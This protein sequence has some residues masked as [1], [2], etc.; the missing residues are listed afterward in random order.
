MATDLPSVPE[1]SD[2]DTIS[3]LT[4][5]VGTSSFTLPAASA[6]AGIALWQCGT[7]ADSR[8]VGVRVDEAL[9]RLVVL[10]LLEVGTD[11]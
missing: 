6:T 3:A 10:G 2:G 1:M 4:S 11:L 9:H 5:A 8:M 7:T